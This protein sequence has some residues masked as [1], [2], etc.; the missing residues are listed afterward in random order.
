[1]SD[2]PAATR[3]A[4]SYPAAAAILSERDPVLRR[5]VADAGPP[6]LR[7]PTETNIAALVRAI[8]YQQLAGAAASAIHGRLI[9]ALGG[10]VTA[11]RL[12]SLPADTL[13]GVGLSAN[14]AAA[15]QD[16][17]SKVL[18]GTV[19]LDPQGLRTESDDEVVSRRSAVLGN[20]TLKAP[21]L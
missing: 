6:R 20:G 16:L 19:V 5:L 7:P 3:R 4:R 18:Y 13:R 8:V 17:A 11:E 1:M 9:A 15:V 21:M 12:L 10:E 2:R 14:K